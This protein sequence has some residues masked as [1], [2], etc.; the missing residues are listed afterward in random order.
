MVDS[1][2]T[3]QSKEFEEFSNPS[4]LYNPDDFLFT[5]NDENGK[6]FDEQKF[7]NLHQADQIGWYYGKIHKS[8][9]QIYSSTSPQKHRKLIDQNP[10]LIISSYDRY[11]EFYRPANVTNLLNGAF[12]LSYACFR[13]RYDSLFGKIKIEKD[14]WVIKRKSLDKDDYPILAQIFLYHNA[15]TKAFDDVVYNTDETEAI[16]IFCFFLEQSL[17][18]FLE[19]DYSMDNYLTEMQKKFNQKDEIKTFAEDFRE[20]NEKYVKKGLS[21]DPKNPFT[22][23]AKEFIDLAKT[24]TDNLHK[25]IDK[26]GL[27]HAAVF[28]LGMLNLG[29]RLDEQLSFDHF[30]SAFVGLTAR[31]I[32]DVKGTKDEIVICFDA[33]EV[34]KNRS[35]KFDYISNYFKELKDIQAI[36]AE[37][38]TL[39]SKTAVFE[40]IYGDRN[41]I[42]ELEKDVEN[43]NNNKNALNT[44]ISVLEKSMQDSKWYGDEYEKLINSESKKESLINKNDELQK[45]IDEARQNKESKKSELSK[46]E[47]VLKRLDSELGSIIEQ[48]GLTESELNTQKKNSRKKEKASS[49]KDP[50]VATK[51]KD[52]PKAEPKRETQKKPVRKRQYPDMEEPETGDLFGNKDE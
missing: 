22:K 21:F 49:D 1:R 32:V 43:L 14:Q 3:Q 16:K 46:L 36:R 28:L 44:Q 48:K 6:L 18:Y 2:A 15:Q 27:G 39:K 9:A 40:K 12:G 24:D 42:I 29:D 51:K 47:N 5:L 52:K 38:N 25:L 45:E 50:I 31:H 10:K 4:I 30:V 35:R 26:D 13:E 37:V 41:D 8:K 33:D 17:E 7:I 34:D 11:R 19:N 23:V 20:L